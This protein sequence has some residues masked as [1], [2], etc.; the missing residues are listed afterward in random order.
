MA[1]QN[2]LPIAVPAPFTVRLLSYASVPGKLPRPSR[3][4]PGKMSWRIPSLPF[5]QRS[6]FTVGG[7]SLETGKS[8]PRSLRVQI[9]PSCPMVIPMMEAQGTSRGGVQ[10]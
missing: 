4:I 3:R 2:F 10:T 5:I 6:H 8:N 7:V 1:R 9:R